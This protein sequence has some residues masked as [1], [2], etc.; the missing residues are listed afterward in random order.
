MDIISWVFSFDMNI[1]GWI[2]HGSI[3]VYIYEDFCK[4]MYI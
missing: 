1:P 4:I 3:R 2:W